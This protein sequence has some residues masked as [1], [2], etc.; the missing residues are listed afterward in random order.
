MAEKTE[1]ELKDVPKNSEWTFNGINGNREPIDI[2]TLLDE[3]EKKKMAYE[4]YPD[5]LFEFAHEGMTNAQRIVELY[6]PQ[7]KKK[8]EDD[9]SKNQPPIV[10][11][12]TRLFLPNNSITVEIQQILGSDTFLEQVEF[13]AF[14]TEV[15]QKLISDPGY[16]PFDEIGEES[17][18]LPG[19][20]RDDNFFSSK[21]KPLNIRVWV[22]S[23]ALKKLYDI[24]KWI[25]NASTNKD[26]GAGNF[27][28]ELAPTDTL[29]V[30]SYGNEFF[31]QYSILDKTG[32]LNE[33][34]FMKF[35]QNN[36]PIFI[37]FEQLQ[38]EMY[39]D[40][41]SSVLPRL[42]ET[43]YEVALSELNNRVIWDMMGLIDSVQISVNGS[44]NDYSV[45]ISGRDYTKLLIEDGSY[46]IPLKFVEGSQD[47]WFYGGDPETSWFKRNMITGA[48]DYYF[49]YSFQ[50]IDS[51]L[52]FIINQLSNIGIVDDSLFAHCAKVTE[53][54]PV[55][56]GDEKYKGVDNK[57][58]GVW[59]MIRIF[60]DDA[61][62]DRRIVDR[63]LVNP[64][65]SLLDLFNKVCQ[66]PFVEFWG[67]T[68]ANEFNIIARQPPFTGKAIRSVWESESYISVR[69]DDIMSTS[70]TYDDRIYA[71][72]RIM[73]QNSMM[74]NSQFSSLAFVPI[75]FF[76]EY[77]ELF[78]NKRCITN[79]IYLSEKSF[80]GKGN[81]KDLNTMSQALLNDLLFVVETNAYL[82]FTRKGTITMNGDRRIKV[83]TF[84]FLEMTQELYYVT[85]VSNTISFDNN[86]VDRTTT[87][88]VERGMFTDLLDGD[89]N[90]FNI[91]DIEGIRSE[92]SKRNQ[93][94]KKEEL[95]KVSPSKFGVNTDVFNYFL[96]RERFKTKADA[97]D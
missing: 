54:L 27:S 14:W 52:W 80:R 58:K 2:N 43:L 75:I 71:W 94:I 7:E 6:T 35:L 17:M 61:L 22:Y 20:G 26:K 28:I 95:S 84:I 31:N 90:Y 3:L 79:D 49:A 62:S 47:R 55:E 36:D 13:N 10:K 51:V 83:G 44:G 19:V 5:K 60:V 56:T 93:D 64:E 72:Y 87:L 53:K 16:V 91:I 86:S 29:K 63:S 15:Q 12:G 33:D 70:L 25:R 68:W 81:G 9:I 76:N 48:F 23:R 38:M 18:F 24:S 77:C 73:P 89:K 21:I 41:N 42:D 92:I 88:T 85:A 11:V 45:T 78:G 65:G 4:L 1:K 57:V 39:S 82:P 66:E 37:R 96:N 59:Q 30:N 34:W 50:K 97:E 40:E 46:F 32:S 67:D 74:G 8:Y 69:V